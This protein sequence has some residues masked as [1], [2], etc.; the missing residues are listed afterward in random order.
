M[1]NRGY[2]RIAPGEELDP[3]LEANTTGSATES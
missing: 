1:A 2:G 3:W